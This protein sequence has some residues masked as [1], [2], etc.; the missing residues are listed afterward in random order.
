MLPAQTHFNWSRTMTAL[1][2]IETEERPTRRE[3]VVQLPYGLPGFERV[4]NYALL[5]DPCEAP[6]MWFRLLEDAQKA[7]LVVSPQLVLPDYRPDIAEV[8]E[9]FLGLSDPADAL[10]VNIVTLR[11][12]GAATVNLKGPIVINRHSLVGKQVIPLNEALYALHH[13]LPVT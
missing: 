1:E 7:F 6:F 13:P 10:M 3:E 8:D 2:L 5:A 12:N 9:E 4:K 11:A